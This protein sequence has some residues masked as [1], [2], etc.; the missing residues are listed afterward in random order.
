MKNRIL[1]II[2]LLSL[3]TE[4]FFANTLNVLEMPK[5]FSQMGLSNLSEKSLDYLIV[6]F[7]EEDIPSMDLQFKAAMSALKKEEN[8]IGALIL[9]DLAERGYPKA[10]Y[11]LWTLLVCKNFLSIHNKDW[12]QFFSERFNYLGNPKL[13]LWRKEMKMQ[14]GSYEREPIQPDL[15]KTT[16]EN[17]LKNR[18]IIK[19]H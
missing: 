16:Q 5:E 7:N 18:N 3:I 2:F 1:K 12:E 8:K 6:H 14:R 13:I 9:W 10:Y 11:E 19:A 15:P 17:C 4:L